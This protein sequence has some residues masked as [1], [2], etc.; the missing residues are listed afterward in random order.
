M[1]T[2]KIS[3]PEMVTKLSNLNLNLNVVLTRTKNS[4]YSYEII[5]TI[6][7]SVEL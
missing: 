5:G 7:I 2:V 4:S 1:C 6:T 3:D